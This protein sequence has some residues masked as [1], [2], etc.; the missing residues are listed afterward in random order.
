MIKLLIATK[1]QGKL[2]EIKTLFRDSRAHVNLYF[3]PDFGIAADCA[4][5]GKTFAENA[6]IKSLFYG[7]FVR[8]RG[9]YVVGDD[10]GLT[11]DALG[12]APGIYSSRY[13][14]PGAT[15]ETNIVKLLN[16]LHREG[17]R[18]AKFITTASLS[19]EG[20]L[21]K[22]FTGEVEGTIIDEGRGDGGFG[23]DPVFYYPPLNKTFA[24]LTRE[25]KNLV[26]HRA[27]AFQKLKDY[28][29]GHR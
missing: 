24:Q 3:L 7:E 16:E 9:I 5:T 26:S 10:S 28:I 1:N 14:G 22:T 6:T 11:V 17:N 2:E 8:G 12:G 13:S 15:D 20:T 21:L 4:E 25:E 19:L 27:R 18:D 29:A 23:Y